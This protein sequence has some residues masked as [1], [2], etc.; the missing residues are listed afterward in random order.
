M[1]KNKKGGSRAKKQASKNADQVRQL[2]FR[3]DGQY[4][5]LVTK[6]CGNAQFDVKCLME[7]GRT[8]RKL[9]VARQR[10]KRKRGGWIKLDDI[11]LVSEREFQPTK[12]DIIHSYE[13]GEVLKLINYKELTKD[14]CN[15]QDEDEDEA[16]EFTDSVDDPTKKETFIDDI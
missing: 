12:C 14:F 8:E 5:A 16:F 10:N 3:E 9:A 1:V 2:I 7:D 11:I 13:R 4:Y 6:V 15:L